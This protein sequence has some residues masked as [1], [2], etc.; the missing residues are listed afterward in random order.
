MIKTLLLAEHTYVLV[1]RKKLS[2]TFVVLPNLRCWYLIVVIK[3]RPCFF[4]PIIFTWKLNMLSAY[5]IDYVQTL[6]SSKS[7]WSIAVVIEGPYNFF[8]ISPRAEMPISIASV[9]S[10]IKK[11]VENTNKSCNSSFSTYPI[12]T[13]YSF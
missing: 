3:F 7:S 6:Y 9:S 8:E 11:V 1:V 12:K 4:R 10:S 5:M 13:L 2:T